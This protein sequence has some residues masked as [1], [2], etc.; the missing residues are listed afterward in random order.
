MKRYETRTMPLEEATAFLQ[1]MRWF[2]GLGRITAKK[3]SDGKKAV[4]RASKSAWSY[5][6]EAQ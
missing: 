3:T 1:N 5:W 2:A 6:V 4:V